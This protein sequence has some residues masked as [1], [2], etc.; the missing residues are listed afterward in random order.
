[1][2]QRSERDE[3]LIRALQSS[4]ARLEPD[5]SNEGW[6]FRLGSET[7]DWGR[8][9]LDDGWAAFAAELPGCC[10]S[11]SFWDLLCLN[12]GLPGNCKIGVRGAESPRLLVDSPWDGS[13]AAAQRCATDFAAVLEAWSLLDRGEAP[14]SEFDTTAAPGP[15]SAAGRPEG[16][17]AESPVDTVLL[18]WVQEA[19]WNC[20]QRDAGLLVVDFESH[21]CLR[22]LQITGRHPGPLHLRTHLVRGWALNE[23]ALPDLGSY[24]VRMSGWRRLVRVAVN[25]RD[26]SSVE[27]QVEAR[28]TPPVDAALVGDGLDALISAVV[29]S[30]REV[31]WIAMGLPQCYWQQ[32]CRG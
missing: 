15:D 8:L 31:G 26:R 13:P 14:H 19:G 17:S 2:P 4:G 25:S 24:L 32:S 18:E 12:A 5:S 22:Q 10:R 9:T 21:G 27:I 16:R 28:L 1:M 6:R 7:D 20:R 23:A 3:R 29:T 11:Q 30:G